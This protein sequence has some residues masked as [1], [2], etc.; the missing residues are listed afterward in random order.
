MADKAVPPSPMPRDA[1]GWQVAPAPDGRGMPEAQKP[2]PP[3]QMRGFW[4]F[5]LVLLA[6][7]WISLLAAQQSAAS[8]VKVPFSPYFLRQVQAGDVKSISARGDAI[9]GTF[10]TAH[11]YPPNDTKAQP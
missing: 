11:R 4:I 1:R 2:R 3:H 6:L 5:V 10:K 9:E 7:N 8:R